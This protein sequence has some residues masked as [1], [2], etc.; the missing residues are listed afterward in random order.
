MRLLKLGPRAPLS[1]YTWIS[2]QCVGC[3]LEARV[4]GEISLPYLP[5]STLVGRVSRTRE[6]VMG[7]VEREEDR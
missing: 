3:P 1:C 6:G 2:R 7:A 5:I 4:C